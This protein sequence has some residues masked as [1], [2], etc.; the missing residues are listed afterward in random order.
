VRSAVRAASLA[1]AA[2]CAVSCKGPTP[3]LQETIESLGDQFGVLVGAKTLPAKYVTEILAVHED[4]RNWRLRTDLDDALERCRSA[5][6]GLASADYGSW[7]ETGVV[8]AMLTAMSED[9]PSALVRA[10]A[11]DTLAVMA[12]WTADAVP[13]SDRQP[14]EADLVA[15]LRTVADARG[16]SAAGADSDAVF[17]A[18]LAE[19]LKTLGA[20]RFDR[21]KPLPAKVDR[22]LL[23]RGAR[24]QLST[25]RAILR[26]V[27]GGALQG[28]DADPRV[29]AAADLALVGASASAIRLAIVSASVGG[30]NDIV[31]AAAV[32]VL[33]AARPDQAS[34]LLGTILAGDEA[35]SVRR[36]AA[37]VLGSYPEADAVPELLPALS[38]DRFDVRSS[39]AAALNACT[40]QNFGSDRL[41]WTKWWQ[42]RAAGQ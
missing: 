26:A 32:R 19:A 9:H 11:L 22:A 18:D 12:P 24:S 35:S 23:A 8:V 33:R 17:A 2:A 34:R 40:G 15:A 42:A 27:T 13:E 30:P 28:F 16:K 39:A 7:R 37:R 29:A 20:Y 41:A 38:D 21:A 10:E 36:E 31:R 1:L 25:A 4:D 5:V 3:S 6:R 14:S